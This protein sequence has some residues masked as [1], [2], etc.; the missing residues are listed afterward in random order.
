MHKCYTFAR[1][2]SRT[3]PIP[4]PTMRR[5]TS[6]KPSL[7]PLVV[8]VIAAAL[9]CG[10]WL[11]SGHQLFGA[12]SPDDALQ[13]DTSRLGSQPLAE[14]IAQG[15]EIPAPLTSRPEELLLHE[16]HTISYNRNTLLPNW[17]AW[18]LTPERTRGNVRRTDDFQPDLSIIKGPI[19]QL[20][21]Y[22]HSGYDRGHMC[23]AAD[24]KHSRTA[25]R[26]SFLLSN[27]CPQTA[28][29]NRGDWDSLEKLCRSWATA[30][31]SVFIVSGPVIEEGE[32]YSGIGPHR[33]AVPDLFF[34]VVLRFTDYA[35]GAEAIGFLFRNDNSSQPPRQCVVSVDSV[36]VR[37]G[38]DFFPSLPD[39]V[40]S[41]VEASIDV[42]RW[43]G[44]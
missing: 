20:E 17:V 24:N 15:V 8:L 12:S 36:E 39:S 29:L 32:K 30:Y 26:E 34:K 41:V 11:L 35:P 37:T 2:L 23:P 16:G 14:T 3:N 18:V 44:L 31:D 38:I 13:T 25:M 40:E 28:E 27:I 1:G 4:L 5:N 19:A 9:L 10:R 22:R 42:R 21:D 6:S 33:V 43:K 7:T